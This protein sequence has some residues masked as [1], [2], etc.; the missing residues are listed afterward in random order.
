[1]LNQL[2]KKD[3]SCFI[4]TK[5]SCKIFIY[6]VKVVQKYKTVRYFFFLFIYSEIKNV[7]FVLLI[8]VKSYN[9]RET[10]NCKKELNT[11]I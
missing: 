2:S 1:M 3:D 6:F 5:Y 8:V 7:L 4:S 9:Y 11:A 10:D